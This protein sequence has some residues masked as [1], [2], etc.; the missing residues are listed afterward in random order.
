MSRDI[1]VLGAGMVGVSVAW[2]LVRR[3][4]RV[5]LVDRR[6]PGCETSFGNAGIIQREAVRPNAFP[7][8]I[9]TLL[10]VLPNR[11]VDIRYRPA[12][13][14]RAVGPLFQ[15]WRNSAGERYERIVEEWAS[16]IMRSLDAHAPM[17]AAAGA[18][19]LIRKGGWLELY[20]TQQALDERLARAR[21]DRER[22]GVE[23]DVL[24]ADALYSKEPHLAAGLVGAVH[25][26]QPWMVIDP[27]A[28]VQAYAKNFEAQGG[29]LIQANVEKIAAQQ[30]GWRVTTSTGTLMADQVVVALGPWSADFLSAQGID[31]PL[32]VK[33]GYHMHYSAQAGASLN[34]WVMD[35]ERGFLL[36]PMRAG[37]RLT[38]GAELADLDSPPQYRQLG[39]AERAA[40]ELFPLGERRDAQPWK[41]ARP[42]LPDMKPV[43]GPAPGRQDLWLAFGH[44]HQGFTLGPASGELL[45][46]MMDG[47]TPAIDMAPFSA[48]RF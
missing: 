6:G 47:E 24:D 10:R 41:G 39:A 22:F 34:H 7:R 44:G 25:W 19:E 31:V 33:R 38:T 11:E 32:F 45:A 42:C 13:M 2:H 30:T 48:E 1:L 9:G 4:H 3:G 12:D 8:D 20:R 21:E 23:F 43:I 35:A 18:G 27:G 26:T 17:I 14:V 5:T 28:L 40:R 46:Q 16:L 29:Q 15:Y 37:I 36:E